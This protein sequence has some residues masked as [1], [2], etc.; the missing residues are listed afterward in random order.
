MLLWNKWLIVSLIFTLLVHHSTLI[1]SS[2]IARSCLNPE[3]RAAST[4]PSWRDSR[5]KK[6][7]EGKIHKKKSAKSRSGTSLADYTWC[8]NILRGFNLVCLIVADVSLDCSWAWRR[9]FPLNRMVP[10]FPATKAVWGKIM[11]RLL[12]LFHPVLSQ[13][14]RTTEPERRKERTWDAAWLFARSLFVFRLLY[15][16]PFYAPT[17]QCVALA[18]L[19]CPACEGFKESCLTTLRNSFVFRTL[20]G[21]P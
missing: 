13:R 11:R 14:G 18:Q 12:C 1:L 5:V 2:V 8:S 20:S 3:S 21:L 6:K 17:P 16:A 7:K 19:K 9:K 4:V 10:C 15:F